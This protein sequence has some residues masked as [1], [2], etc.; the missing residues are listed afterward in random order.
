MD[1]LEDHVRVQWDGAVAIVML[2]RP[3][4]AIRW[5]LPCAARLRMLSSNSKPMR[6]CAVLHRTR[7]PARVAHRAVRMPRKALKAVKRVMRQ[8]A[9]LPLD[10]ALALENRE[11]LLLFD[12][13]DNTEGMRSF[14]EKRSPDFTGR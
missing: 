6:A 3:R 11:F 5:T 10:T 12:T 1:E 2:N 8:G 9:D 13:A 4:G 7:A 14:L